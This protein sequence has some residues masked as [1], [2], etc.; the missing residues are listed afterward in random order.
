LILSAF[1]TNYELALSNMPCKQIQPLS[2]IQT[3]KG[4]RVCGISP[5]HKYGRKNWWERG[6]LAD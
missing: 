1:E 4:L 2:R 6:N 5:V 3:L